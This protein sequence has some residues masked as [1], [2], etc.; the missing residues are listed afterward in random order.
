MLHTGRGPYVSTDSRLLNCMVIAG[1]IP[2]AKYL[3]KPMV[4]Y[5]TMEF[6]QTT[7]LHNAGQGSGSV[8]AYL[9]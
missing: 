9:H 4:F 3:S 1:S 7:N 8:I 2:L 6:S 5:L